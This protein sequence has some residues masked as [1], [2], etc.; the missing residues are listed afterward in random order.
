MVYD[1]KG[2]L[3]PFNFSSVIDK[4]PELKNLELKLTVI[5]FPN[6][7]DSTN[8][9][10]SHWIDLAFIISNNYNQYNGFV[11]L[12]GTDTMAFSASALSFML[13]GLNK[14][15]IF[16]GAQIPIGSTRSD[17]REN[18][19]TAIEIASASKNGKPMINEVCL[20]FNFILL[21]GNRAQKIRSSTFGAFES[22]NYPYLAESGV[23]IIFNESFIFP[24]EEKLK[25]TYSKKMDSNVV[26]LKLFPT[27]TKDIV[28][29]ILNIDGL[30]G[31]ILETFGSGNAFKSKWFIDALKEAI[32]N[33]IYVVNVSQCLG[34]SV[35]Q[36]LYETSRELTKIGVISGHDI[37]TE[38]ALAKMMY[39]IGNETKKE[40][41]IE[42]FGKSLRGEISI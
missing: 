6:P 40:S 30:K 16:T 24:H 18:L 38:A 8:I 25:L 10:V 17:A 20:Y 28:K 41:I 29:G 27:M 14:P 31:V 32:Q 26:I 2:S 36:G 13:N 11:V 39:L 4:I 42:Q 37:T 5:S 1:E 34:G 9:D 33:N 15:V 19:I 23:D 7:V 3:I 22:E 35:L 21:R 12:H